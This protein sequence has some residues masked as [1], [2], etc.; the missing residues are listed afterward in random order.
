MKFNYISLFLEAGLFVQIILVILIFCS[1]YSWGIIFEKLFSISKQKKKTMNFEKFYV[2]G[3]ISEDA[4]L[5]NLFNG[6]DEN[7]NDLITYQ[8]F[9]RAKE[10]FLENQKN[11]SSDE[12]EQIMIQNFNFKMHKIE[13]N[14]DNLGT[15]ASIGPY[16]SL[17]GTMFGI[18]RT[19]SAIGT[20][21]SVNLVEI[22]PGIGEV[23]FT[24]AIG[25]IVSIPATIFYNKFINQIYYIENF[26]NNFFYDIS[27]LIQS[28]LSSKK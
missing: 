24:T 18:I 19:F 9:R 15:I 23:L 21:K 12:I 20:S 6:L 1:I 27:S 3:R 11:F 26:S 2:N 10:F 25:L 28:R 5:K 22:G 7:F 13:K 4:I 16:V 17:L 8:S 14:L